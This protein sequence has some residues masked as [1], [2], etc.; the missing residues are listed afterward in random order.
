MIKWDKN[1]SKDR[2]YLFGIKDKEDQE[3]GEELG[4]EKKYLGQV[5]RNH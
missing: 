3:E 5:Q 1:V 4:V 2:S